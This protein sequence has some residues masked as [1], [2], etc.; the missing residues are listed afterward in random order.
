MADLYRQ[1]EVQQILNIAI[2]RQTTTEE[3]SRSQ[4][5]EIAE[6]MGISLPE[7]HEAETAWLQ[8]RQVDQ[9]RYLFDQYRR[10]RF[11][12]RVTRYAIVN[13]SLII[14]NVV[15][16]GHLSWALYPLLGWG[17]GVAL[18]GWRTF[19]RQGEPYENAFAKW[20]RQRQLKQTVGRVL[21]RFLKPSPSVHL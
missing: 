19:Q 11:R 17:A 9:E 18:G 6:E 21:D 4:L 3:L 1:D 5:I 16:V 2:A 14:L 7:L 20:Q 10:T 12:H 15:T 8:Q 13:A